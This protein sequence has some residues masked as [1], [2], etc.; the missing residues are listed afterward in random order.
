MRTRFEQI[1]NRLLDIYQPII[2]LLSGS[3][4][5]FFVYF[6]YETCDFVMSSMTVLWL[7]CLT[8]AGINITNVTNRCPTLGI[9]E[10]IKC[11]FMFNVAFSI[12]ISLTTEYYIQSVI[13]V[14]WF[15]LTWAKIIYD[16]CRIT[17]DCVI[18]H[19]HECLT[20]LNNTTI[21]LMNCVKYKYVFESMF[22][23][24]S[25]SINSL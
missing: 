20:S 23:Y 8:I 2:S 10:N 11:F 25:T 24:F 3:P 6:L 9:F 14:S 18:D 4:S 17:A 15:G 7:I 12:L 5:S 16:K 19:K 21:L 13:D 1:T 22:H